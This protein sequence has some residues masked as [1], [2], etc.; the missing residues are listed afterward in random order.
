MTGIGRGYESA[1]RELDLGGAGEGGG[2]E[3][4]LGWVEM[5]LR[6]PRFGGGGSRG[7]APAHV[8]CVEVV[9]RDTAFGGGKGVAPPI[10]SD[11]SRCA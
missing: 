6:A 10:S 3:A 8:G 4:H 9:L 2:A 1:G 5:C 11:A 7:G